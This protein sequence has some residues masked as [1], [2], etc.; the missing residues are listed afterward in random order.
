LNGTKIIAYSDG[1]AINCKLLH[2]TWIGE[3]KTITDEALRWN[4]AWT[5]NW[6]P[7]M[8]RTHN[9]AGLS[10]QGNDTYI[11]FVPYSLSLG[12]GDI[13]SIANSTY[14]LAPT[15]ARMLNDSY[16]VAWLNPDLNELIYAYGTSNTG[17]NQTRILPLEYKVVKPAHVELCF[18]ELQ[19]GLI[20]ITLL[21]N[22]GIYFDAF[23]ISTGYIPKA[24]A[25]RYSPTMTALKISL[26]LMLVF[27]LGLRM[28]G[29]TKWKLSD[30]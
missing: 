24:R 3:E 5:V 12:W 22:E 23:E 13:V 27:T 10:Y 16:L 25:K 26:I 2:D 9:C 4:G 6:I 8:D 19:T 1:K 21:T 18:T 14:D 20:G 29:I 17:W 30:L 7:D 15:M 28:F 11:K